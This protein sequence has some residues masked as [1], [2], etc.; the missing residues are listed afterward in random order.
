MPTRVALA[1]LLA[2]MSLS[3]AA[4]HRQS[5]QVTTNQTVNF[6]P[7]GTV[8]I[9]GSYGSL[10]VEGW[11]RP[12]VEITVTRSDSG[13]YGEKERASVTGRLKKIEVK[14]ESRSNGELVIET[15]FP[16]HYGLFF[17]PLP[18]KVRIGEDMQYTIHV[19]RDTHLVVHHKDG[20]VLIGEV[21]G[22]IEASARSGDLVVMLPDPGKYAIDAKVK[23][24]TVYSDFGD[25]KHLDYAIGEKLTEGQGKRLYLRVGVGGISVQG[26]AASPNKSAN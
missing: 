15:H 6:A 25:A 23:I 3:A 5:A 14:T 4:P 20:N 2:G 8:R 22:E 12:E 21:S 11:D 26:P 24:G 18:P 9:E 16:A 10:D 7:G 13:L 1:L 17:P 19:P